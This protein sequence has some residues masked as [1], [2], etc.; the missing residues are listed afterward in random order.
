MATRTTLMRKVYVYDNGETGRSAKPNW[1]ELRFEFLAPQKD[2]ND[3]AVVLETISVTPDQFSN[4]IKHCA[5]GHGISQKIGDTIAGIAK[6]AEKENISPD[7][8]RGY[9]DF[10]IS[11]VEEALSDLGEDVWVS[12]SEGGNGNAGVTLLFEAVLAAYEANGKPVAEDARPAL[13]AKL[14]DEATRKALRENPSVAAELA[15]IKAERA[16]ERAKKAKAA[17]KGADGNSLDKLL[18]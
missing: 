3:N 1:T 10:A 17:A 18:G 11:M 14:K 9:V 12:E 5:L 16:A 7:A 13:A 4:A 6:K 2:E 15:K 8:E